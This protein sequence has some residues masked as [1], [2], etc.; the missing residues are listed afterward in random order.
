MHISES[1]IFYLRGYQKHEW[2]D[3]SFWLFHL[4]WLRCLFVLVQSLAAFL[5]S[6]HQVEMEYVVFSTFWLYEYC[7]G[8]AILHG[9]NCQLAQSPCNYTAVVVEL[10]VV[11]VVHWE[12]CL[13]TQMSQK[14]LMCKQ[15]LLLLSSCWLNKDCWKCSFHNHKTRTVYVMFAG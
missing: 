13:E 5:S 6:G 7:C 3:T 15:Y 4:P 9:E 12:T 10:A 2:W 8:L 14:Q 11:I 1:K